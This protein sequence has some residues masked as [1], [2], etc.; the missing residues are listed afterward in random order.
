[1][2]TCGDF[3]H[4]GMMSNSDIAIKP[5]SIDIFLPKQLGKANNS[6]EDFLFLYVFRPLIKI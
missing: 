5:F 2:H 3:I 6:K 4:K 1:M